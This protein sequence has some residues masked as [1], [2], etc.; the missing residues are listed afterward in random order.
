[1]LP[2]LTVKETIMYSARLRLP[3]STTRSEV[4]RAVEKLLE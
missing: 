4:S 1:M 2:N 3:Q